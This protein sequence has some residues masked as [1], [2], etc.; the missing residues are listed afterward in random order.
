MPRVQDWIGHALA[1]FLGCDAATLDLVYLCRRPRAASF[2]PDVK[3][4]SDRFGLHEDVLAAAV[5]H[6]DALDALGRA[7]GTHGTLMAAR[8]REE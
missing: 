7:A 8:D 1:A 2:L 5:R 4:I 3:A 6:A